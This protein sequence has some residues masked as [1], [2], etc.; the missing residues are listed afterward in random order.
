MQRYADFG[1]VIGNPAYMSAVSQCAP[2]LSERARSDT[3][4]VGFE[5][6]D[7]MADPGVPESLLRRQVTALRMQTMQRLL[8]ATREQLQRARENVGA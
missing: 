2:D 6:Y 1:E 3:T 5:S 7:L 4:S 8:I